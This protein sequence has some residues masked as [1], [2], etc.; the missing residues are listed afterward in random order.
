[1]SYSTETAR[2]RKIV[3]RAVFSIVAASFALSVATAAD[4]PLDYRL[5][6]TSKT[7]TMEKELNE[8]GSAGYHFSKAMGGVTANAGPEV[9]L[10]MV[11][12]TVDQRVWKYR[13]FATSRTSTMQ[14]EL[15]QAADDGYEYKEQTVFETAFGGKEVVVIME[16]LQ[17]K[18]ERPSSYRL[19]A[20]TKTSTMQKE[21][22]AAAAQGYLLVG[23]SVGKTAFGGDEVVAILRKH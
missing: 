10:V 18:Q 8:A 3:A 1:M 23:L 17:T 9:V 16:Q 12:D 11:K 7:S 6:A 21:L 4:Q 14:K 2:T 20:T 22:Q 19:L 5:L 15:Q 13:L